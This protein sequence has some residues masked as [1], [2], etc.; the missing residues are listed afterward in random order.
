MIGRTRIFAFVEKELERLR[1]GEGVLS[2]VPRVLGH[3]CHVRAGRLDN[4]NIRPLA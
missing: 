4:R 3:C 2:V 1:F